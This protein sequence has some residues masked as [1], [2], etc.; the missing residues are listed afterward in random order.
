MSKAEAS[1]IDGRQLV[2][3]SAS[4]RRAA[5]LRAAGYRFD[6]ESSGVNE[7]LEPLSEPS[8]IAVNVAKEK[9]MSVR[10]RAADSVVIGADTIVAFDGRM[11][12]KPATAEDARNM[13]RM[14]CGRRH[15][16][17][18]G[19]CVA[20]RKAVSTGCQTT[21]VSFRSYASH[22]I[23]DYLATGLPFDRAGAYGIQDEPFS[24]VESFEGCY[25]NVVGLPMCV[26]GGLLK[27]FGI[28]PE[29]GRVECAGHAAAR[30][31]LSR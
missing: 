24:P 23:D 11:L 21:E 4:P 8:Q 19:V 17:V 3:A 9:A 10:K 12:G 13:L 2:L 31:E 29:G 22:E 16:V 7:L 15:R 25:L 20:S 28:D 14:L 30:V 27:D 18:T 6:V 26:T 5:I 1:T